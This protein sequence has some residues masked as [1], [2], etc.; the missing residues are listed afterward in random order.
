MRTLIYIP[1]IH[2]SADMGSLSKE[3][4]NKSISGFG[5][6]KWKKHIETVN[7]YWEAIELYFEKIDLYIKGTNIYQDGMFVDGEMALKIID[8]GIKSGSKNSEIVLKL[9]ERGAT[10]IKTEDYKM[11]KNEYDGLKSIL[12]AKSNFKRLFFLLRYKILKPIFLIRR[13]RFI[14]G[15]IDATLNQNETGILFIGAYHNII[16]RLPEDITVIELKE[17][18][19]IRKYQKALQSDSKMK[20]LQLEDLS[21]Y[22]IKK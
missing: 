14:A 3:L 4:Q 6:R 22:L 20:N 15:R 1:I 17:I 19:K 7:G 13:D 18:A 9:I 11:V 16:K 10:L 8:E 2:S 5:E 12:K 21:Q